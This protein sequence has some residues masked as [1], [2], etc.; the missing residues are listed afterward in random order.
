MSA[1]DVLI[2]GS[3][4]AGV[5]AARPLRAAGLRVAMIDGG[6]A[7]PAVLSEDPGTFSSARK[8]RDDQWRWFLGQDLSAIPVDG[9]KGG[10][11]GGMTSGNR[12]YITADTE[13]MLP[14]EQGSNVQIVQSLAQG[15]LAAGWGGACA[16]F[17]DSELTA[18][19]LPPEAMRQAEDAVIADIGVSGP[20]T[21]AGVQP[22]A[23]LDLHAENMLRA[24]RTAEAAFRAKKLSFVQPHSALLTQPLGDRRATKCADMDYYADPG[25]SLYRPA[26]TLDRLR[27]E[28]MEYHGG[29]RVDRVA[30]RGEYVAVSARHLRDGT[31]REFTARHVVLA[32]GALNSARILLESGG[33]YDTPSCCLLKP[34]AYIAGIDLRSLGRAGPDKRISICQMLCIDDEERD[35]VRQGCAQLYSYRSL[36]LFRLL[37]SIPL[38]TTLA[39]RAAALLAPSLVIADLRFSAFAGDGMSIA[40]R[41]NG[42]LAVHAAIPPEATARREHSLTRLRTGLRMAGVL[43]VSTLR[44][45]EGSSSH[46]AGTIPIADVPTGSLS[47]DMNGR[48]HGLRRVTVADASLL[49]SFPPLP[50]T[51]TIMA[52]ARRI[53]ESLANS[54]VI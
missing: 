4:P 23:P 31:T 8:T 11:G 50:H 14:L 10:L 21:R 30:E 53:G 2:I 46:Y 28:G 1:T 6:N 51:L 24:Y 45:P 41:R 33:M 44:L 5:H 49:R 19:G 9:L 13:K 16:F 22:S 12:A 29:W 34:H 26:F 15:G 48:V 47:A 43:P 35:G 18:M 39:M 17:S 52:N 27:A 42:A 3:G 36:L 25:Q 32:A 7:A 20:Q 37:Q 40:L 38:S 54:T